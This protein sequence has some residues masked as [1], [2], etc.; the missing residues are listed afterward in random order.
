MQTKQRRCVNYNLVS[1]VAL[2]GGTGPH[3]GYVYALNPVTK[4][5]GPVCDDYFNINAVS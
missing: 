2:I 4:I 3:E 5:Y 1:L